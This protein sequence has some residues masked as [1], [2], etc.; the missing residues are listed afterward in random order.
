[1]KKQNEPD[2]VQL[3][4]TELDE[5][6]QK[7]IEDKLS[8]KD[9][10]LLI[11]A[12]QG[13]LWLSKML[14]A[15]K[16]SLRKLARLFGFK[17]EK[18]KS[19]KN[20]GRPKGSG[21]KSGGKPSGH[22]KNG[23][24]DFSG[25]K[26]VFHE[27]SEHKEGDRCPVCDRGNL[28]STPPGSFIHFTGKAPVQAEVHL[29][30][31]LRCSGCGEIFTAQLPDELRKQKYDES[32]DVAIAMMRYGLGVPFNRLDQWQKSLGIPM[33]SS[34]Q[35]ERVECLAGSAYKV[36]E[37]L[38]K[39]SAQGTIVFIDDTVAKVLKL[40]EWLLQSGNKRTGIMTT[41]IVSQTK[42]GNITLF[43]TGNRHAGEN[44]ERLLLNRDDVLP[45]M[46]QM[47]D[48][49]SSNNL[50]EQVS[51]HCLCNSHAR[52][53][54]FDAKSS[55]EMAA[56]Y[57]LYLFGKI[58][59]Y[60]SIARKRELTNEERLA[61]HQRKSLPVLKKLRR[62][63]LKMFYLKK[64]DPEDPLGQAIQY[65]FNHWEKLTKFTRIVGIPLDN[66]IVERALKRSIL[67]RKNSYFFRTEL[68]AYVGDV[69]MSLIETAKRMEIN[70]F[71]YLEALHRNRSA[72]HKCPAKWL[73]WTYQDNLTVSP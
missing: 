69:L 49:L 68:G 57:V 71:E 25:A 37:E 7:I 16:L 66:N 65:L 52:R 40:K 9:K 22:G 35:W 46:I 55:Y 34:T 18:S 60:D 13:M 20:G 47:S 67:H 27:H 54:F 62:W 21:G 5:L 63:C 23:K 28:Y 53:N 33:P 14:E 56:D 26:K 17:T 12:L 70:P 72:V 8:Q 50:K 45:L 4:E 29:L 36:F 73:P 24:D 38:I 3:S 59:H 61:F 43:F 51:T 1:M 39:V 41:G 31:K 11:K 32:C 2:R 15:K 10:D 48:A 64:V 42:Y 6:K 19:G 44:L 58:Y 30:E